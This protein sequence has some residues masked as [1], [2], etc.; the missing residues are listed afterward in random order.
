MEMD[1]TGKAFAKLPVVDWSPADGDF[2]HHC[3]TY[4]ILTAN[5]EDLSS[6]VDDNQQQALEAKT[7][8]ETEGRLESA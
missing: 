4:A 5:A 2:V 3:P 6:T 7:E 1:I 8:E